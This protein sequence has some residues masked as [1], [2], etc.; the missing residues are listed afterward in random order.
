MATFYFLY[1]G[2]WILPQFSKFASKKYFFPNLNRFCIKQIC[3]Q[4]AMKCKDKLFDELISSI[5]KQH[6]LIKQLIEAREKLAVVQ[7]EALQLQLE[8][9]IARLKK[10]DADLEQLSHTEDHIHFIQVGNV[11]CVVG[12]SMFLSTILSPF[13]LYI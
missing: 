4:T 8:A 11:F 2:L 10:R 5:Q 7:A 9:E 1:I 13:R 6:T 12:Q 3:C